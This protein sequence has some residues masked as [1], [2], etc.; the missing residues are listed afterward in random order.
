MI[1][2]LNAN[3]IDFFF[4]EHFTWPRFHPI[5]ISL[6]FFFLNPKSFSTNSTKLD[7]DLQPILGLLS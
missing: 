5:Q 1:E 7:S 6:Q 2:M 3:N 4:F